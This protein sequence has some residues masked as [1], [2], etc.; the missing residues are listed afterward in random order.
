MIF[1]A[2]VKRIVLLQHELE[3]MGLQGVRV[4][5]SAEQILELLPEGVSKGSA[6]KRICGEIGIPLS[7]TAAVGDFDNDLE[8]IETAQFGVAV[9]NACRKLR[10]AADLIVSSNDENG[11][12]EAIDYIMKNHSKLF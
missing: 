5:H 10:E 3:D 12:A 8:M 1:A 11:V 9:S 2:E 6:L 7:R 4:V